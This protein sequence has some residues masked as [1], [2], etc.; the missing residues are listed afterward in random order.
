MIIS[1]N[2]HLRSKLNFKGSRKEHTTVDGY[3]NF[4]PNNRPSTLPS[5]TATQ[6][7]MIDQPNFIDIN[8]VATRDSCRA[9]LVYIAK[10]TI[11]QA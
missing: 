10:S 6:K 2:P 7:N 8:S 3:T 5:D 1:T 11:T 9:N 4:R